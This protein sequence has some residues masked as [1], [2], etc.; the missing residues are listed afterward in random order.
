MAVPGLG[1]RGGRRKKWG[2][3]LPLSEL[4]LVFT[5]CQ[6]EGECSL[7]GAS[8]VELRVPCV[9]TQLPLFSYRCGIRA[10]AETGIVQLAGRLVFIFTWFEKIEMFAILVLIIWCSSLRK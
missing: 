5:D 8:F 7:T 3:W 6:P 10:R 1:G 2:I 9:H 4:S